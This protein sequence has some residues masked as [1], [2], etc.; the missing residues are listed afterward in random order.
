MASNGFICYRVSCIIFDI[1]TTSLSMLNL[2]KL[3]IDFVVRFG[4]EFNFNVN[5]NFNINDNI[6]FYIII[7][8]FDLYGLTM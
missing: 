1:L 7:V 5:I 2:P 6:N 8:L 4:S 3:V